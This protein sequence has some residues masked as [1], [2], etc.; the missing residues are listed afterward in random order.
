MTSAPPS[1]AFDS[2]PLFL[3]ARDRALK[4]VAENAGKCFLA[5]A[6]EFVP[7]YLREHGEKSGEELTDAAKKAGIVPQNSDKAFGVV[8]KTLARDG[9]IERARFALRTK[10]HA[11]AGASIWRLKK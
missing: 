11:C 8:Y 6:L 5:Q 3:V 4:Q 1:S 2:L 9:I 7:Q 10:G